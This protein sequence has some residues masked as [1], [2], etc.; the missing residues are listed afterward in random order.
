MKGGDYMS[1]L[2]L[3]QK[4][5]HIELVV[6]DHE[7]GTSNLKQVVTDLKDI[8]QDLDK[9]MA[10]Q[11]EKQSHLFYRIEQLQKEIEALEENGEK[12]NNRQRDLIEK[13]LMAFL[14]GLITYI[15]SLSTN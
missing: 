13:A 14:G 4:L 15:F 2:E 11:I 8:V 1:Q 6:Q 7:T 10:I 12:T 9:S 5:K 3:I